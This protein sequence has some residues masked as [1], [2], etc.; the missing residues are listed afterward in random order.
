MEL[1]NAP[2]I[3]HGLR[4]YIDGEKMT[5]GYC[6]PTSEYKD[7]VADWMKRRHDWNVDMEWN[8][9][10]P[11]VVTAFF[12]AVKAF[13][14]P[15]DGVIIFSPVYYP[16]RMAVETN[17]RALADVPLIIVNDRYEI[18]WDGFETAAKNPNNKMLLF[19][20]PHNPVGRVWS[21]REL[22]RISEICL[23]S[24]VLTVSDEI[25]NDLVMPG[26]RHTVY[27]K[28]SADAAQNSIICTSPSKSFSLAGLMT[29][30]I[31]V[32]NADLRKK[33]FG[34][35]FTSALFSL[36]TVGLKACEIA[37]RE[38]GKWLDEAISLI[39]E[40][41]KLTERILAENVPSVKVYPLEGTYLQW[42]DCRRLFADYLKLE[43][44]MQQRAFMFLDEGYMFGKAGEGFERINLACP[45]NVIRAALDRFV[46]A[47][48]ADGII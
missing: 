6:S 12:N 16:F 10:S 43:H 26:N 19:C 25:H 23:E 36:N 18:D 17:N 8:V 34:M 9:L 1:K 4:E 27:A 20:S 45:T 48:R 24:D 46:A 32:P 15:G 21:E 28:L 37:Y 14:E 2:E 47:L 44:F 22:R 40:N 11:G 35:M 29:S 3:M 42:W 30:N 13:T 38:C 5:F 7:A 39:A 41:A 31:F 33:F